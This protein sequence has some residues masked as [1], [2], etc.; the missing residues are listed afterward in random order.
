[1]PSPSMTISCGA[2]AARSLSWRIGTIQDG[3][4]GILFHHTRTVKKWGLQGGYGSVTV[5]RID[6]LMQTTPGISSGVVLW[7]VTTRYPLSPVVLMP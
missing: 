7:Q 2:S 5:G 4:P 1:M 6:H 3:G